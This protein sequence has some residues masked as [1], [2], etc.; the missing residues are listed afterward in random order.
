MQDKLEE[1][2]HVQHEHPQL[3]RSAHNGLASNVS[4]DN[5]YYYNY[6][7]DYHTDNDNDDDNNS[8]LG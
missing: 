6:S 8:R 7:S 4:T 2:H 3:S 5:D 1:R